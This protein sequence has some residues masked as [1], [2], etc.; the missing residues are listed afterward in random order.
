MKSEEI[1]FRKL[2][3]GNYCKEG[4]SECFCKVGWLYER[5]CPDCIDRRTTK[6]SK[7]YYCICNLRM[8]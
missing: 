8:I 2:K 1:D 7:N 3:L 6:E 4:M 5:M